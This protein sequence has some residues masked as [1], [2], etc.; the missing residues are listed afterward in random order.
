MHSKS[1]N[2]N[3]QIESLSRYI[4][5]LEKKSE[6]FAGWRLAFILLASLI[7]LSLF[8][9][10]APLLFWISS[11]IA[12]LGFVGLV[13]QHQRLEEMLEKFR[14]W[15]SIK[16]ES[17]ARKQL[18]WK[19]IPAIGS[20]GTSNPLETDFD[21]PQLYRL[22]NTASS[23]AGTKRLRDW[24]IQ[25]L[26]DLQLIQQRQK[27]LLELK[28]R[29]SYRDKLIM[30]ARLSSKTALA[31]IN[32]DA[33][34]KWLESPAP[35][36][37]LSYWLIGLSLLQV[38]NFTIFLLWQ[39]GILPQ[40]AFAIVWSIY[41]LLYLSRF[42]VLT[43]A[44]N[45]SQTLYD[46][47]LRIKRIMQHLENSPYEQSPQL[48][49][50]VTP[51]LEAKPSRHIHEL[52]QNLAASNLRPNPPLWLLLNALVPWDMFFTRRIELQKQ[53]LG[54]A[55]PQWLD[56]WYE[57]EALNSLA[58]FAYLNPDSNLPK[59]SQT[60]VLSVKQ[61]EHPL[62]PREKR[63]ANDF[64]VQSLGELAILTGSN[65]SGKSSFLRT[66]GINLLLANAGG[67]VLA[68]AFQ[69]SLFRVFS[70]I[71]VTDSLEDGISYFYA[72]VQRLRALLDALQEKHELP[73]F[74]VIDEIFRGTNN[75]ERLL[76]SRAYINAL[77]GANGI[78]L[79][80]TH[81]LELCQIADENPKV[82]N[83]HFREHIENGT[84]AFDYCLREGISPSNNALAIMA[85]AGLPVDYDAAKQ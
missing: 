45:D 12:I 62:I 26:P 36:R 32:L 38:I 76:G 27:L 51:I 5:R 40:V 19:H 42:S 67:F 71:R 83:L 24:I 41:A 52:M 68:E 3:R 29:P 50:L 20:F 53:A 78:G 65:M 30:A 84:M 46:L 23:R 77:A 57:I 28:D 22:L 18:A 73:L 15:R 43:Q 6:Q 8:F 61:L 16:Q 69:L 48:R 4:L 1:P 59:F 80:A 72:E 39:F 49:K 60:V 14:I 79:I 7:L 2:Y 9:L 21:L 10:A 70:C 33:L 58:H 37:P 44:N 85:M 74:Y 34:Y 13:I 56:V 75:R 55:V 54:L 35:I 17:L 63:V 11:F 82:R 31:Q 64:A 47:L 25:P 81:D 66:L